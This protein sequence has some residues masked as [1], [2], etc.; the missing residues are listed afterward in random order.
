MERTCKHH[1]LSQNLNSWRVS[2]GQKSKFIAFP[3]SKSCDAPLITW[4][5]I[6]M[7]CW[8]PYQKLFGR[9]KRTMKT[10]PKTEIRSVKWLFFKSLKIPLSTERWMFHFGL[11]LEQLYLTLGTWNKLEASKR[12]S[13]R[14]K[15]CSRY[16][17]SPR[18]WLCFE[19]KIP[20]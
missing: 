20:G 16:I 17:K 14:R 2:L 6:V 8:Q 13:K 10:W 3:F 1:T 9:V 4:E 18:M 7:Y 19:N 12:P 5:E 15:T 11:D